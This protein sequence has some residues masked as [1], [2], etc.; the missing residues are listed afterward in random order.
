MEILPASTRQSSILWRI[1]NTAALAHI[2]KEGGLRGRALLEGAERIILLLHQRQLR[3][4]PAFIS[5]EENVQADAASRFQLVPDWHLDPQVFHLILTLW[6]P[7]QIDLFVSRRS[8]QTMRFRF[9]RATDHPE[10]IDAL[11]MRWDF[12]LAFLFPPIP[13][14][15]RVVRKLELSKGIFLLVNP[16]WEAQTWFGSLQ[17][18]QVVDV[19]RLPF[20][21]DLVID[22]LTGEPPLSLER[23]FLVIWKILGSRR[24][25]GQVLPAYCGRMETIL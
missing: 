20:H 25:L 16:Y 1:D 3:I 21:N 11:S 8:A 10:A 15:K 17:A 4:L 2:R 13:L 7:P 18:L 12:T 5:S 19:R 22:L 9:W 14:L 23:L 24:C 6:G